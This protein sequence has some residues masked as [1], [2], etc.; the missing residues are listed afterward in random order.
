MVPISMAIMKGLARCRPAITQPQEPDRVKQ[1]L[2]A[3]PE[4]C[5]PF[6]WCTTVG[7]RL[8]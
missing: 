7:G 1:Y 8:V 4:N 2:D 6:W 3:G 5:Q